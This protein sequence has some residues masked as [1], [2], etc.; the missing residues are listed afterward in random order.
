MNS[1]QVVAL[2]RDGLLFEERQHS[3]IER[4]GSHQRV[5]PVIEF[6][7]SAACVSVDEGLL[8]VRLRQAGLAKPH[9]LDGTIPA[10][11]QHLDI[12]RD[13]LEYS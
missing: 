11:L 6:D 8:I 3:I 10:I 5:L 4:L 12:L 7:E 2:Q 1:T 9:I 13:A